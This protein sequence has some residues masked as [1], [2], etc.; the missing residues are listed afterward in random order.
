MKIMALCG[1]ADE[2]TDISGRT[3]LY[4]FQL[5]YRYIDCGMFY[6]VQFPDRSFFLIDSAHQN[7]VKDH[8]R[9]HDFL[10]SLV[11][12][13][14]RI[15]I[16]GW[17]FSHAHQDHIVKFM[18]FIR[19]DWD[20]YDIDMLYYNFPD[21]DGPIQP[22]CKPDDLV[23]MKEFKSLME[24]RTDLPRTIL[25]LGDRFTVGTCDFEVLCTWEDVPFESIDRFNDT[26]TVLMM[27][28]G[29]KKVFWPGDAGSVES[30]YM[31]EHYG[32]SLRS[33]I[34]QLS[35]HGFRGGSIDLYRLVSAPI[36]LI[37]TS[38]PNYEKNKDRDTTNYAVSLSEHYFLAGDETVGFILD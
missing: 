16:R 19:Q 37:S 21:P 26:S 23:T 9:I 28:C 11:G 33:D 10:R 29:D 8:V 25:H 38:R 27:T 1:N 32:D 7:S 24:E 36:V 35:H 30:D 14:E 5:D 3:M 4:Q 6:A 17:F 13:N 18:D 22:I 15:H 2:V 34:L 20:D 31:V 12:D